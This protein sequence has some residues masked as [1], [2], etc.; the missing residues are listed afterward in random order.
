M[1]QKPSSSKLYI[2]RKYVMAKS[3]AEAI[4]KSHKEPVHEVYVDDE[5]AKG[6]KERLESAIGYQVD[7]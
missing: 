6:N 7:T 3:V 2:V 4:K 5:W 1:N